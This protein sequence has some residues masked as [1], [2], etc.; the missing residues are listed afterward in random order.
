MIRIFALFA[1]VGAL[2]SCAQYRE[3]QANCFAF[4]ASHGQA[5]PECI[6]TP[7]QA[8]EDGIDI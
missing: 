2:A 8:P 1:A 3:P 5:E 6:F 7:L 4:R